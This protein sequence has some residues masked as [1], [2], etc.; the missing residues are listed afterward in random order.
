MLVASINSI[1]RAGFTLDHFAEDQVLYN[2]VR[3]RNQDYFQYTLTDED[4]TVNNSINNK[5]YVIKY[6][7]S[8]TIRGTNRKRKRN[9]R[10]L[11]TKM[12]L[13]PSV[14]LLK[15]LVKVIQQLK[16]DLPAEDSVNEFYFTV[17]KITYCKKAVRQNFFFFFFF[18]NTKK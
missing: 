11:L 9:I 10:L 5:L 16:E 18:R 12:M 13:I 8:E 2:L 7:S 14:F 17:K 15:H 6:H 1:A 3:E 4:E